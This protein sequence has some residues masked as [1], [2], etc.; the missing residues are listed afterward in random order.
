MGIEI[1]GKHVLK[2]RKSAVV[3]K[4]EFRN[5]RVNNIR[6]KNRIITFKPTERKNNLI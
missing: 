6:T 5:L 4:H 3:N 1:K 2:F